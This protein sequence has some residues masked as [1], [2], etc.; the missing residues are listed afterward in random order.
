M[1][2]QLND[3]PGIALTKQWNILKISVEFQ[4]KE[5]NRKKKRKRKKNMLSLIKVPGN[6]FSKV[7]R[8]I[9]HPT[10]NQISQTLKI[11]RFN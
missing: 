5:E 8:A 1:I 2:I 10:L 6:T 11:C 4:E 3:N 9:Y 7:K